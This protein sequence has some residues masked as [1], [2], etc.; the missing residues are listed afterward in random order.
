MDYRSHCR[1]DGKPGKDYRL[2]LLFQCETCASNG[3]SFQSSFVK[4][5]CW[6][7]NEIEDRDEFKTTRKLGKDYEWQ[8][9][10]RFAFSFTTESYFRS[11]FRGSYLGTD[12]TDDRTQFRITRTLGKDHSLAASFAV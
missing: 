4:A 2:A 8:C 11:I 1:M 3:N 7:L 6:K 10:F 12:A 5:V 9:R